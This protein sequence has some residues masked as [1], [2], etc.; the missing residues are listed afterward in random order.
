MAVELSICIPATCQ[1]RQAYHVDTAAW[2]ALFSSHVVVDACRDY[3]SIELLI[4]QN[5][6][7]LWDAF[8]SYDRLVKRADM[9]RA[10]VLHRYGGLYLDMD[11]ECYADPSPMLQDATLVLQ[12]YGRA[13]S[14]CCTEH[15]ASRLAPT[16]GLKTLS[17]PSAILQRAH[18]RR[19]M[20]MECMSHCWG[21]YDCWPSTCQTP[22]GTGPSCCHT[23]CTFLSSSPLAVTA[24]R[25]N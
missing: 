12:G 16:N 22:P 19:E 25:A 18:G 3:R 9:A 24:S 4:K 2:G 5:Y 6:L 1:N 17:R 11:V 14:C 8:R 15:V 20:A 23:C 21:V 10:L 7:Y 13:G